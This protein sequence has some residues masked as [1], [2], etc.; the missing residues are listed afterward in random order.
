ML[1]HLGI[2]TVVTGVGGD[3]ILENITNINQ[4]FALGETEAERLQARI[5]IFYTDK[6][7]HEWR[8]VHSRST[9]PPIPILPAS[10]NMVAMS[11]YNIYIE[12]DIWPMSPFVSPAFYEYCQGLPAHMRANKNILRAY[13]Q[14]KGFPPQIYAAA[15]NEN[16]A[17]FLKKVFSSGFYD[18][19]LSEVVKN[20]SLAQQGLIDPVALDNIRR[21]LGSPDMDEQILFYVYSLLTVEL[22]LRHRSAN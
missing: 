1:E 4:H 3:D 18:E 22:N 5:P 8:L 16:F 15:E 14:A 19:L 17:P 9:P 21:N 7:V 13:H 6:F 20:S 2:D 12:H 10:I 11:R